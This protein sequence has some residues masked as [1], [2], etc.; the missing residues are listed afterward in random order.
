MDIVNYIMFGI[1]I[2]STIL[3]TFGY[4]NYS[5]NEFRKQK[6][7]IV[8]LEPTISE[9]QKINHTKKSPVYDIYKGM[10]LD[11]QIIGAGGYD[12][13]YGRIET[14]DFPSN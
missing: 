2:I 3:I 1:L 9:L 13:N 11:N 10:F 4:I 12:M 5:P 6:K 14:I 8:M 7:E